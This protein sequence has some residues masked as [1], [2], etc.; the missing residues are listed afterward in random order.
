VAEAWAERATAGLRCDG[1]AFAQL[2]QEDLFDAAPGL[3]LVA[4]FG[5]VE[6]A[7][8]TKSGTV[9]LRV[10]LR[11]QLVRFRSSRHKSPMPDTA[12]HDWSS[13]VSASAHG[14]GRWLPPREWSGDQ[15]EQDAHG[16]Q[17]PSPVVQSGVRIRI[18]PPSESGILTLGLTA[19]D[20]VPRSDLRSLWPGPSAGLH[21]AGKR[22]G[23]PGGTHDVF[24]G[25]ENLFNGV[26]A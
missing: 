14:D 5:G 2:A 20:R 4:P 12:Q 7:A 19:A 23:C 16:D 8:G 11:H 15:Q 24:H 21:P 22:G 3:G 6:S 1:R 25:P 10:R 9:L 13:L 18:L 26:L 17:A